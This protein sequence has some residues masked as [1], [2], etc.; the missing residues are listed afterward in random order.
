MTDQRLAALIIAAGLGVGLGA[1]Y[2]SLNPGPILVEP[3]HAHRGRKQPRQLI[4]VEPLRATFTSEKPLTKRQK[5][6][7]RGKQ[8]AKPTGSALPIAALDPAQIAGDGK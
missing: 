1:G 2:G 4:F 3:G 5:R 8:A 7:L 6:R